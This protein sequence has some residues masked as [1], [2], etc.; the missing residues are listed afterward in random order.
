MLKFLHPS[1]PIIK[2]I[3]AHFVEENAGGKD[4]AGANIGRRKAIFSINSTARGAATHS[5]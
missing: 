1:T 5:A 2:S 3:F 4:D